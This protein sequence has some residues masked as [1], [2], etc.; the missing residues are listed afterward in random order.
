M[1]EKIIELD[2]IQKVYKSGTLE[3]VVLRGVS[4]TIEKGEF[5]S[6]MAPSGSGK[7][8]LMNIIGLLDRPTGG[9]YFLDNKETSKLSDNELAH[10]R[11]QYIGF[12]FQ[13]FHLLPDLTAIENVLLPSV[14]AKNPPPDVK[15]RAKKYLQ[16][17]GLGERLDFYPSELSGGQ[18]QRVA[19]ARSLINNPKLVLADEPTGNLD[20]QSG[21]EVLSV[22][23]KLNK[24]G[25]TILM[26]THSPEIALF[27]NRVIT[28]SFGKVLKEDIIKTPKSAQEELQRMYVI[29]P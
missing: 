28:L 25:I 2:N 17:V 16:T 14:Y 13:Q 19:I 4:F 22:F 7:T 15:E 27:T 23:Q 20:P 18:Q 1:S 3:T 29:N 21:M 24:E 12:I 5:A 9:R 11:N 6:I 10:L 26:V 8:T